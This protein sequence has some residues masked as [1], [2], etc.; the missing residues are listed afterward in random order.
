MSSLALILRISCKRFGRVEL[1]VFGDAE[2][3][4]HRSGEQADARGGADERERL[5]VERHRAGVHAGIE[6]DVDLEILHR[7]IEI[8]LDD[9]AGDD[10]SR[11]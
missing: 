5:D 2:A 10:G 11:R 6:R 1:D 3:S 8:F 7:G 4:A 9:R